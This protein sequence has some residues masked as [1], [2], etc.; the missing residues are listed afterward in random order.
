LMTPLKNSLEKVSQDWLTKNVYDRTREPHD[1]LESLHGQYRFI[2][3]RTGQEDQ[4]LIK[5]RRNL[6]QIDRKLNSGVTIH[7]NKTEMR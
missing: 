7:D 6:E 5:I 4:I 3:S 1:Y 2:Q